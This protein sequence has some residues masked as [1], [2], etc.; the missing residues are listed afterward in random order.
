MT[1]MWDALTNYMRGG[2][3]LLNDYVAGPYWDVKHF[4]H[5][6]QG[7]KKE[8]SLARHF[9]QVVFLGGSKEANYF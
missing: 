8:H 6:Y 1:K 2:L 5:S 7:K 4:Q 9:K 3:I